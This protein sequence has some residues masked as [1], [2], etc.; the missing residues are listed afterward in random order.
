MRLQIEGINILAFPD[1][2]AHDEF[3]VTVPAELAL[4][5]FFTLEFRRL[6]REFETAAR[7]FPFPAIVPGGAQAGGDVNCALSKEQ[8]EQ[9][10]TE[11]HSRAACERRLQLIQNC[12]HGMI[13][14]KP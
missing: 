10:P 1:L 11:D 3:S 6:D 2:S 8:R 5:D 14:I 13:W 9:A 12:L 7:E 4:F